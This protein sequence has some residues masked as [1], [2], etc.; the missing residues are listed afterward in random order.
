VTDDVRHEVL[1]M[2][3]EPAATASVE[4]LNDLYLQ[5]S[6]RQEDGGYVNDLVSAVAQVGE[7][8][9]EPRDVLALSCAAAIA[10]TA[11]SDAIDHKWALYTP[12]DAAVVA[13]ALCAQMSATVETLQKLARA[14]EQIIERGDMDLPE[15]SGATD[16][17]VG[18]LAGALDQIGGIAD[19]L[20][21]H[22]DDLAEVAARIHEVPAGFRSSRNVHENLRAVVDLLA[23]DVEIVGDEP[24]DDHDGDECPCTAVITHGGETYYLNFHD[25]EWALLRKSD[26]V[27]SSDGRT[28]W[29][30]G[31][32]IKIDAREPLVHPQQL[33]EEVLRGLEQAAPTRR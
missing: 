22:V 32:S 15:S 10:S 30:N 20:G 28:S 12:Q 31:G 26:A 16:R 9:Y 8:A 29:I 33:A 3:S 6:D 11:L 24:S 17:E 4:V 23:V 14:V 19:R 18:D 5:W 21:P 27:T 7:D 13:S 2:T 25:S 1:A